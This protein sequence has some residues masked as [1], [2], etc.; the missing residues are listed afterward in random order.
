[1]TG[2]TGA[3]AA[4]DRSPESDLL[5]EQQRLLG[6]D[7]QRQLQLQEQLLAVVNVSN[8]SILM[9]VGRPVDFFQRILVSALGRTADQH[10]YADL[11][12]AVVQLS[13][14]LHRVLYGLQD[15]C[16]GVAAAALTGAAEVELCISQAEQLGAS[17]F[18]LSKAL[19]DLNMKVDRLQQLCTNARPELQEAYCEAMREVAKGQHDGA[20]SSGS[21]S[22]ALTP[23]EM[24]A[25]IAVAIEHEGGVG[26]AWAAL[27]T[28]E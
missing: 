14:S 10:S 21:D 23:A 9:D 16:Y 3:A 12:K 6:E 27:V 1:M 17:I 18:T 20:S 22:E 5:A 28:M 2:H 11:A 4:G 25:L 15:T 24:M 7:R 13:P 26:S 8:S 19:G